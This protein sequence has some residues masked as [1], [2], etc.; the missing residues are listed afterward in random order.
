MKK[1][2]KSINYL[3]NFNQVLV[4]TYD[5]DTNKLLFFNLSMRATERRLNLIGV[6]SQV[7][8]KNKSKVYT[9]KKTKKRYKFIK[10]NGKV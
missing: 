8:N 3:D 9:N 5:A 2:D 1:I 6:I 4:D 7:L 10:S